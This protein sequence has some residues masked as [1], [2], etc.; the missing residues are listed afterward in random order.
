MRIIF[1]PAIVLAT[2]ALGCVDRQVDAPTPFYRFEDSRFE[3]SGLAQHESGYVAYGRW[4]EAGEVQ[5]AMVWLEEGGGVDLRRA[6]DGI[7][8]GEPRDEIDDVY[9]GITSVQSFEGG[10][11]AVET[12]FDGS[13]IRADTQNEVWRFDESGR[14]VEEFAV[15]GGVSVDG[16]G[17]VIGVGPSD[18]GVL[19]L[20]A[21]K[22]DDGLR[23]VASDLVRPDGDIHAAVDAVGVVDDVRPDECPE[24]CERG[25]AGFLDMVFEYQEASYVVGSEIVAFFS[26]EPVIARIDGQGKWDTS[27]GS[28]GF[29]KLAE[30]TFEGWHVHAAAQ[31]GAELL[32]L[33]YPPR[34]ED[35]RVVRVDLE[36]GSVRGRIDLTPPLPDV[37]LDY[38]AASRDAW[39]IGGFDIASPQRPPFLLEVEHAAGSDGEEDEALLEINRRIRIQA[40]L[41]VDDELLMVYEKF[42]LTR[43]ARFDPRQ[44]EELDSL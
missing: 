25:F 4:R 9:V 35:Y 41:G 10:L 43:I 38:V 17:G 27:F 32:V 5:S 12:E 31:H 28:D 44:P 13:F 11:L 37:Y 26:E 42:G 34:G 23:Q 18:D 1:V 20:R 29:L 40:I 15:D 30:T 21:L 3:A 33:L 8:R 24:L 22:L 7:W 36:S 19:V 16:S 6:T 2:L 14:L 39:W